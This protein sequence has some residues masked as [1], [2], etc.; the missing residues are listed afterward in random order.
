MKFPTRDAAAW[1]SKPV[2]RL[3]VGV[4]SKKTP[5]RF[6]TRGVATNGCPAVH[7]MVVLGLGKAVLRMQTAATNPLAV[8]G[9]NAHRKLIFKKKSIDRRKSKHTLH[10][11][12]M[13]AG[14]C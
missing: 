4:V 3:G 8:L 9:A 1:T 2:G 14:K 11:I 12:S 6:A 13:T 10:N 5:V 7:E